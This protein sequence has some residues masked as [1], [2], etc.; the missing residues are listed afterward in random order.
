MKND[1]IAECDFVVTIPASKRYPV[2]NLSQSCVVFFY[3]LFNAV[4]E[5]KTTSHVVEA[6][7]ADKKQLLKMVNSA[8]SRMEFSTKEKTNTQRIVWK[9]IIGKR[10]MSKREAVALMGFIRKLK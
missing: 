8:L 10:F 7:A 1:E 5:E 2:L 4:A 6:S 3:E 9:R